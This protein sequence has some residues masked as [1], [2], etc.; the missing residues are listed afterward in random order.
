MEQ[1]IKRS[2]GQVLVVHRGVEKN[3][4][5][6]SWRSTMTGVNATGKVQGG[7][8][9]VERVRADSVESPAP[10]SPYVPNYWT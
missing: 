8:S 2:W 9:G 10:V 3:V 4:H 6:T 7:I 5:I 1:D